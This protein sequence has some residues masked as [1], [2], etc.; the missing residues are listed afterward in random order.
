MLSLRSIGRAAY[1]VDYPSVWQTT[2]PTLV[3]STTPI[4]YTSDIHHTHLH[5]VDL[6]PSPRLDFELFPLSLLTKQKSFCYLLGQLVD[7]EQ[8]RRLGKL[9][10]EIGS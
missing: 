2:R 9:L 10:Q 7:G 5:P 1:L 3:E 6:V 4:S 8:V